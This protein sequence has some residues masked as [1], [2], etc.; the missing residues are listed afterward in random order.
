MTKDEALKLAL[1][2]LENQRIFTLRPDHEG[3]ELTPKQVT[4][5]ITA[6]KQALAAQPAPVQEPVAWMDRDG[7]LYAN[8]PPKN[9]CPPHYPLY[10]TPPAAQRQWV[11]L[12]DEERTEIR[13]EHYARTLPLMDAVEAKLKEKNT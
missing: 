4:N 8:E 6:I 10:T 5:A 7:D 12:T 13:Q 9:W 1:E 2:A 3:K 11:S